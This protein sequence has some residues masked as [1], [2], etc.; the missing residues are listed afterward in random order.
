[1]NKGTKRNRQRK[2]KCHCCGGL[3]KPD[4]R[5]KIKQ[6]YCCAPEC[7]KASQAA[8]WA[9]WFNRP[10]NRDYYK[11]PE[12]IA[13]T[14]DWRRRNPGYWRKA[15]TTKNALPKEITAQDAG[16]Q[17]DSASLNFDALP[18]EIFS[19]Q[20]LLVGLIANLT[21]SALPKEI[22]ESSRRFI[23]LGQDILGIVPGINPKGGL[24]GTEA[25][26]MSGE[27][28]ACTAT[29]QLGGSPTG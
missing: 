11:G 5:V 26:Y 14:Q 21:G 15:T 17:G 28:A 22:A 3:Y 13:K 25:Y 9:S 19:Q 7:R 10:E 24:N 4:P 2:R 20:A 18:K 1:M 29:V 27:V 16:M 8:S 6:M 23:H 12:Q